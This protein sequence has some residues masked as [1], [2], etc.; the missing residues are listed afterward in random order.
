MERITPK[1]CDSK[2]EAF[3]YVKDV[4]SR[5]VWIKDSNRV[6]WPVEFSSDAVSIE[7]GGSLHY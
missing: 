5:G 4:R 2:Q 7:P 1:K 6:K 3:R